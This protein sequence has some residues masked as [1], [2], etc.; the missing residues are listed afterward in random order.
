MNFGITG[1]VFN[2]P[3]VTVRNNDG[4]VVQAEFS[5]IE[6]INPNITAELTGT[7]TGNVFNQS[8]S[9]ISVI[10]GSLDISGS[11]GTNIRMVK[12]LDDDSVFIA[13]DQRIKSGASDFEYF[14]D[15]TGFNG[16]FK[17]IRA[18]VDDAPNV[19]S[20]ANLG[21]SSVNRFSYS[22][23]EGLASGSNFFTLS[24]TSNFTLNGFNLERIIDNLTT[25]I[26]DTTGTTGDINLN[27]APVSDTIGRQLKI[28][29]TGG[30]NNILVLT[31]TT[32]VSV[33]STVTILPGT[34][35][36]LTSDGTTWL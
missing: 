2:S 8:S 20:G 4:P 35:L 13:H 25:A 24:R 28:T 10:G 18:I 31:S 17:T 22:I 26:V 7:S 36:I 9:T 11:T 23:N 19:L 27:E 21:A 6:I 16:S 14:V 3:T 29:N 33:P 12:L 34:S 32:G 1:I 15:F 5:T 30:T